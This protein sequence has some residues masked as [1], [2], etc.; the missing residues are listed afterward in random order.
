MSTVLISV[1]TSGSSQPTFRAPD[2]HATH[3]T[4]ANALTL[5]HSDNLCCSEVSVADWSAVVCQ[6]QGGERGYSLVLGEEDKLDLT[7][8]GKQAEAQCTAEE[9]KDIGV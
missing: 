7:G 4:S 3:N 6:V 8:T 2:G 9:D 5:I 1:R